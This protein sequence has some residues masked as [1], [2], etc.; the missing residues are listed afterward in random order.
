MNLEPVIQSEVGEKE[1]N[2]LSYMNTSDQIRMELK[3]WYV[4]ITSL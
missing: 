2:K 1:K 4:L 3:N